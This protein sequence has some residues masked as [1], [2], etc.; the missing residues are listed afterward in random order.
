MLFSLRDINCTAGLFPIFRAAQKAGIHPVIGIDFRNGSNQILC[1]LAQNQ[2]GST[3]SMATFRSFLYTKSP[4]E[5]AHRL[6]FNS[7]HHLSAS[8]E[9]TLS[10]GKMNSSVYTRTAQS[11]C[12]LPLGTSTKDNSYSCSPV[13]FTSKSWSSTHIDF[14]RKHGSELRLLS[15]LPN[16]KS[17]LIHP[18]A[19]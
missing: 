3:N 2:E 8:W 19:F 1:G 5:N 15:K 13:N 11:S 17:K 18:I 6:S 14:L 12:F 4:F 7:F 16:T 10:F 9:I